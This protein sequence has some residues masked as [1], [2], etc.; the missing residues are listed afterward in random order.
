MCFSDGFQLAPVG[1]SIVWTS[2]LIMNPRIKLLIEKCED[3]GSWENKTYTF[4]KEKF[5]DLLIQEA[6][7]VVR[8]A[9]YEENAKDTTGMDSRS[10]AIHVGMKGGLIKALNR[11][12]ELK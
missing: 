10:V 12:G 6:L 5:A 4:D 2:T 3:F 9:W 1:D 8:Q 11:L 7:N